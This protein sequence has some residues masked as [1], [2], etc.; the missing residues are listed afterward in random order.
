[1]ALNRAWNSA[2]QRVAARHLEEA[3]HALERPRVAVT[4]GELPAAA[5]DSR[6]IEQAQNLA[7]N[8]ARADVPVAELVP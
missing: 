6:L 5:V 3:A 2:R 1:M 8:S 7:F 4:L